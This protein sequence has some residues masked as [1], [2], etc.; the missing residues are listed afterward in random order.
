MADQATTPKNKSAADAA[1]VALGSAAAVAGAALGAI[2]SVYA[3]KYG[4]F[5]LILIGIG[6]SVL[7]GLV[8]RD[9]RS[10]VV[11]LV[12]A[13]VSLAVGIVTE[14]WAFPFS[15][16]PSFGYFLAHVTEVIPF[17]LGV[18]G[19]GA[20]LAGLWTWWR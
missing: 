19:L 7:A 16:D 12:A 14:W 10:A 13:L 5:A 20:A 4:L 9:R 2:A 15:H 6:S 11:S 8:L 1:T 17:H 18:I 3:A